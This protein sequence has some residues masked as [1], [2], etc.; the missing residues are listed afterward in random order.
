MR[1]GRPEGDHESVDF[2]PAC[3]ALRQFASRD[4]SPDAWPPRPSGGFSREL[5]KDRRRFPLERCRRSRRAG[6]PPHAAFHA[7]RVTASPAVVTLDLPGEHRMAVAFVASWDGGLYALRVRDGTLLCASRWR[8]SRAPPFPKRPRSRSRPSTDARAYSPPAARPSTTS[9]P[10]RDGGLG[11]GDPAQLGDG[12]GSSRRDGGERSLVRGDGI[13]RR[14]FY[15]NRP[16]ARIRGGAQYLAGYRVRGCARGVPASV[17]FQ[18]IR[19][20]GN[21][22]KVR[23]FSRTG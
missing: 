14:R 20:D 8:N 12:R 10:D 5:A 22:T 6:S 16:R 11:T 2:G 21:S 1:R 13:H 18:P 4:A 15:P 3:Q 23:D 9:T 19:C 7:V 17:P